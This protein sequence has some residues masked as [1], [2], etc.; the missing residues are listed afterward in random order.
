M[1][2]KD[3][4]S[5]SVN[6]VNPSTDSAFPQNALLLRRLQNGPPEGVRPWLRVPPI[7]S[8]FPAFA[9]RS[10]KVQSNGRSGRSCSP[11]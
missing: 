4:C 11:D 7:G 10:S 8:G 5:A 9:A 6:G 3:C 1:Q 2:S